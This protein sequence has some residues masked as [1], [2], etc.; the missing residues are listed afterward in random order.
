[1]QGHVLYF[2]EFYISWYIV[3][4]V[5]DVFV[6]VSRCLKLSLH[7]IKKFS[8]YTRIKIL[9][10]FANRTLALKETTNNIKHLNKNEN[11]IKI[12][13]MPDTSQTYL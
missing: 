10:F 2:D 6:S 7:I 4:C 1:M 13:K 11:Y 5:H 3:A 12:L 8:I 9:I